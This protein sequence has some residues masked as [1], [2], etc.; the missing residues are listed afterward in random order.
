MFIKLIFFI[1]VVIILGIPL[2][3][4]IDLL[5]IIITILGL[6]I[7]KKI[8]TPTILRNKYFLLLCIIILI[9]NNIIPK[10]FYNEAHQI[11]INEKDVNSKSGKAILFKNF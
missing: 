4:K 5:I 10:H 2:N 9:I 8:D 3:N 1:L 11:F 6:L 7:T